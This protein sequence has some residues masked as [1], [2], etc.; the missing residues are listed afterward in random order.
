MPSSI[1]MAAW[2]SLLPSA[3]DVSARLSQRFA[4]LRLTV[5]QRTSNRRLWRPYCEPGSPCRPLESCS[6]THSIRGATLYRRGKLRQASPSHNKAQSPAPTSTLE[7]ARPSPMDTYM[8]EADP[9]RALVFR[10]IPKPYLEVYRR[11]LNSLTCRCIGLARTYGA[12]SALVADAVKD[13]EL[14][15]LAV[16]R[17]VYQ[18]EDTN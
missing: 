17:R 13:R 9:T 7:P 11:P 5:S 4:I 12:G 15:T 10:R 16:A 8:G 2:N 1:E 3:A 18:G 6:T 14:V